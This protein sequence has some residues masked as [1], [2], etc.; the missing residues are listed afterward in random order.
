MTMQR[1]DYQADDQIYS[2]LLPPPTV[3]MPLVNRAAVLLGPFAAL[4]ADV[5]SLGN[6]DAPKEQRLAA[7]LSRVGEVLQQVDPV[8]AHGLMMDAA[9]AGHLTV[10]GTQPISTPTE[11]DKHFSARRGDVYP[12]LIWCLWEC[13]CDFFPALGASAQILKSAAAEA[14][15]SQKA[16]QPTTG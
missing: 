8:A 5:K 7:A 16:G 12:V 13:V 2:I 1:R 3:A 11:F 9:Y 14:L 4:L 15:K 10:G 6:E